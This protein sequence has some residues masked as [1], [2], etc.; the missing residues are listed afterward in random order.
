[1]VPA[2]LGKRIGDVA[3]LMAALNHYRRSTGSVSDLS[4]LEPAASGGSGRSR[5]P[6]CAGECEASPPCLA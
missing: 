3:V 2:A 6:Y 5:S 4:H 1:V